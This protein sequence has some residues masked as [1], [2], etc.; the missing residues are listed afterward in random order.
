MYRSW[1]GIFIPA[2]N[3]L[4][5]AKEKRLFTDKPILIGGCGRSGTTLL[6]SILSAHPH[7]FAYP[8]EVGAFNDWEQAGK[9]NPGKGSVVPFRVDRMYRSLLMKNVPSSCTRWLEKR[10]YNVLYITE[11]LDYF[12]EDVRFLNMVRDARDVLTSRHPEDPEHYWVPIERYINDVNA[13]LEFEGHPQVHTLRYE[14]LI[15]D[16]ETTMAAVCSFIGE[17][18]GPEVRDWHEHAT[19]RQN[20]AWF[21]DVKDIYSTSIGKWKKPGHEQRL[22]DIMSNEEVLKL[23]E[24]YNYS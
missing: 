16:F 24:H 20:R 9:N 14:D 7:I 22:E 18:F 23:M 19:V 5:R 13:G 3:S 8:H 15:L 11:I 21:T 2:I 1:K 10:P 12:G 17:E 4:G 6:L